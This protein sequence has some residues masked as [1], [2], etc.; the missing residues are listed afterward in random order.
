MIQ[1]RLQPV[2]PPPCASRRSSVVRAAAASSGV[3][4]GVILIA[5][6]QGE[7]VRDVAVAGVG[8]VVVVGPFLQLAVFTDPERRQASPCRDHSPPE[9][10]I[11][12]QQLARLD[13]APEELVGDL[14][15]HGRP[16]AELGH[17]T[18]GHAVAVLRRDEGPVT[19]CPLAVIDQVIEQ[20]QGGL[21][22]DRVGAGPGSQ[23]R[24]QSRNGP[25][26]EG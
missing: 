10:A 18:V 3:P 13:H 20:E 21:L 26:G 15:V 16:H 5:G 2:W 4:R 11:D 19:K 1:A 17:G 6:V 25:T 12:L 23:D 24:G 8:L 14:D 7:E 9:V 22:H